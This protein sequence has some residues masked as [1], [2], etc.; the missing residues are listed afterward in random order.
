MPSTEP[1]FTSGASA[2]DVVDV[3]GELDV[4]IAVGT[5]F[6]GDVVGAAFTTDVVGAVFADDVGC[7]HVNTVTW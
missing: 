5:A 1:G 2:A 6:T 7:V 4:G 3:R